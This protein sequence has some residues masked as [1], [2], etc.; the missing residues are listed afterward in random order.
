MGRDRSRLE[1]V[2]MSRPLLAIVLTLAGCGGAA[3]QPSMEEQGTLGP[4]ELVQALQEGGLVAFLRHA[5]SERSRDDDP[6]VDLEDCSTQRNLTEQGRAQARAIGAAFRDLEIPVE[7]VRASEYCR[8][9]ETAELAFSG[10]VLDRRLTGFPHK[11]DPD[12]ER[13]VAETRALLGRLFGPGNTVL[14]AH[15]VNI[16]PIARFKLGEGELAVFEPLGESTFE[17]LGRIPASAWPQLV[18]ELGP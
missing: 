17:Y 12:Y 10:V 3:V 18:A 6:I 9:R 11:G 16:R 2:S 15:V 4:P 1:S 5:A 14:V 8:T 7:E 13:R